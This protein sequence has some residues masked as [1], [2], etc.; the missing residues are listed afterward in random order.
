MRSLL[1]FDVIGHTFQEIVEKATESW[2]EYIGDSQAELPSG[3]EIASKR[4][5]SDAYTATVYVNVKV[6]DIVKR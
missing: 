2:R 6:E 1:Q 5:L 4:E 3:T